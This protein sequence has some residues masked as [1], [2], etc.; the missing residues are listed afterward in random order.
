MKAGCLKNIQFLLCIIFILGSNLISGQ[1]TCGHQH[2]LDLE[3]KQNQKVLEIRQEIEDQTNRYLQNKVK[4]RSHEIIVPVVVHVVYNSNTDN[5]SKEQILSQLEVLNHDFNSSDPSKWSQ[6]ASVGITFKLA[7]RDP[8]GNHTDGITRT[9]TSTTSFSINNEIKYKNL[10]GQNAWPSDQYLNIWVCDLKGGYL[11]FAQ[12]PG[13][14]TATDGVVIDYKY[15]GTTGTA[16]Y[17]FDLGRT[18]TH[19]VGHWLNLRHIWGDGGCDVDDQVDDTPRA[20][21]PNFGC[22]HQHTSCQS[23]DMHENY[24]DY[25][26]DACMHIFTQGQK[27]RMLSL[28]AENGARHNLLSSSGY[29]D[30][31]S[32]EN[33]CEGKNVAI[34]IL[35]DNYPSETSWYLSNSS[36]EKILQGDEYDRS[37]SQTKLFN[38]TCLPEDCYHFVINDKYADGICCRYGEGYFKIFEEDK[39]LFSGGEFKKQYTYSFCVVNENKPDGNDNNEEEE[40]ENSEESVTCEDGIQNGDEEGVDC[41]G[42]SCDPCVSNEEVIVLHEGYFESG[43]DGWYDGGSDCSRYFGSN[44]YENNYSIKLRD[45]SG[46]GSSMISP[47]IPT[48]N[49]AFATLNFYM[50]PLSMEQGESFIV[51]ANKDG[52]WQKLTT[53]SS[54]QD[55]QN[56]SFYNINIPI[57]LEQISNL[58]IKIECD[59]NSNSDQIFIDAVSITGS[60]TIEHM[61][62]SISLVESAREI[63]TPRF[64]ELAEDLNVFPIPAATTIYVESVDLINKVKLVDTNGNLVIEKTVEDYQTELMVS[65]IPAGA[66]LIITENTEEVNSKMVIVE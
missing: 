32:T 37:Q 27:S 19:E 3:I 62:I 17:P 56:N 1:R 23:T 15:F 34:E 24:M 31:N 35:L 7:N 53:F 41:G 5:I 57:S 59:A 25:T 33:D 63:T 20:A 64:T 8:Y 43:M 66:Y 61:D 6:A 26:D 46:L 9:Y 22:P 38:E 30:S 12:L 2:Y 54:G 49:L 14:N 16:T 4:T 47:E 60:N 18:A 11:G 28:F 40:E 58:E 42:T 10:G 13:G 48:Q 65:D 44:S 45:D 51:Y 36:G 50:L 21:G 52:N 55:F 39:L 29:V